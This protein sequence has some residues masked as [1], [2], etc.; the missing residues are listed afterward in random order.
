MARDRVG[1]DT[2]EYIEFCVRVTELGRYRIVARVLAPDVD[3]DSFFVTVDEDTP[4]SIPEPL[5]YDVQRSDDGF[6]DDVV[7]TRTRDPL[8]L[9]LDP[10]E[11]LLRFYY[12]E[13]NTALAG[14]RLER[15]G[16]APG[17]EPDAAQALARCAANTGLSADEI[18]SLIERY[19]GSTPP[20]FSLEGVPLSFTAPGESGSRVQ[21]VNWFF[22][23]GTVRAN[24]M[25]LAEPP[26]GAFNL[27]ANTVSE[28][29]LVIGSAGPDRLRIATP[30]RGTLVGN[31]GDDSVE[32]LET[33]R[34]VA[35]AGD[36]TV[37]LMSNE[38][39]VFEGGAG[40]DL[41]RV[42]EGGRFE[43]GAGDDRLLTQF[44]GAFDG[45]AGEDSV[46]RQSA[47]AT[48]VDVENVGVGFVPLA[49]PAEPR[50]VDATSD[51]AVLR[52]TPSPDER[53]DG[54]VVT[55]SRPDDTTD[56]NDLGAPP[57]SV[58]LRVTTRPVYVVDRFERFA[59]LVRVYAFERLDDG[60]TLY[61]EP[62]SLTFEFG[63]DADFLVDGE[64]VAD[65]RVDVR[66]LQATLADDGSVVVGRRSVEPGTGPTD[67]PSVRRRPG[68]RACGV[69]RRHRRSERRCPPRHHAPVR[70]AATAERACSPPPW[71]PSTATPRS[72]SGGAT[73][74]C[75][76]IEPNQEFQRCLFAI[77]TQDDWLVCSRVQ[78]GTQALRAETATTES[79]RRRRPARPAL[80]D[81]RRSNGRLVDRRGRRGPP[82]PTRSRWID[83]ERGDDGA[84]WRARSLVSTR[85]TANAETELLGPRG[86]SATR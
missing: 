60:S 56:L 58:S 66:F 76:S 45:G 29:R 50:F 61:S 19:L 53:I 37:A 28:N 33:G 22:D 51:S 73:S 2:P 7:G 62:A 57:E 30:L 86:A 41:L 55:L 82:L 25:C 8:E 24:V 31:G 6:L 74:P 13:R 49:P 14:I 4:G 67:L 43:G 79:P 32:V 16:D 77:V 78:G 70:R 63:R 10:G 80:A 44:A 39:G 84:A 20:T 15:E 59:P 5:I 85:P 26:D 69:R 47:G 1:S 12:R 40:D 42:M 27:I 71:S 65:R 54:Y 48:A 23:D 83:C 34:F 81:R 52:W 75:R 46:D 11:H 64:L 35:G 17:G 9:A 3:Q 72:A 68:E 18:E 38:A 21:R 36:D